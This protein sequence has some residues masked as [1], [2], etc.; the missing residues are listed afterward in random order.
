MATPMTQAARQTTWTGDRPP[1]RHIGIFLGLFWLT[2]RR[3]RR[4]SHSR[5]GVWSRNPETSKQMSRAPRATDYDN[6]KVQRTKSYDFTVV[7]RCHGRRLATRSVCVCPPARGGS[8]RRS[9]SPTP[10]PHSAVQK[11]S[12]W[13]DAVRSCVFSPGC[14]TKIR[15]S[16]NRRELGQSTVRP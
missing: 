14:R 8:N 16:Y 15:R 7:P 9:S 4:G 2:R 11:D 3:R 6:T 13:F 1:R 10:C 12:P 5:C